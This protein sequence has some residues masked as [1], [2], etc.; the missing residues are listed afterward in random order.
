MSNLTPPHWVSVPILLPI[1]T[2]VLAPSTGQ[3]HSPRGHET[4]HR[5]HEV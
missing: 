4:L 2:S 1:V 3:L 5:Y